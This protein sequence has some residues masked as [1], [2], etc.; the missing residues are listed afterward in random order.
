MKYPMSFN[1][2]G[3]MSPKR[4]HFAFIQG[5]GAWEFDTKEEM[6]DW[7]TNTHKKLQETSTITARKGFVM[8]LKDDDYICHL[9]SEEEFSEK[10]RQLPITVKKEVVF[11][12]IGKDVYFTKG[13]DDDKI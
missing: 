5:Y 2:D 7:V 13:G 4:E 9:I 10:I 3:S 12:A 6:N 8:E 1:K 11:I